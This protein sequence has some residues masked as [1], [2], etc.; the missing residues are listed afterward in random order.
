MNY[1]KFTKEVKRGLEKLVQ[2]KLDEGIV[3]IRNVT[4]NNNV[5]MRAVSIMRKCDKATP[6][7][8]LREYY[9]EHKHGKDI[10]DIC[11]EIFDVYL[12]GLDTLK[13]NISIKDLSDFD[14]IKE[15]IYYR[16]V[17]YEMNKT[18]LK[19]VPHIKFLDLAIIFYIMVACHEEGQA[20]ALIYNSH[21]EQW[22]K[23]F[24]EIRDIAFQN[25]WEK[26]PPVIK[27]ME[28]IVSE[29]L[30]EDMLAD[31]DMNQSEDG[32]IVSE[33]TKYGEYTYHEVR[34]MIRE[35]VEKLKLNEN[36]DMYVMTNTL[37]TNGAVCITYPGAIR[38]F[39][40]KKGEDIYII[41]SSVHEVILI[42]GVSWNKGDID[43]M[44]H[45]VNKTQL[46]PVDVLSNHVYIYRKDINEI[47]Y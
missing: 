1:E 17:N 26:Y 11:N 19:S 45:E 35:E 29:M 7:I 28:D 42:P 16:L 4:K 21:I 34:D 3:V 22:N 9:N 20:T 10:A 12:L 14:K 40:E 46:E 43:R 33:E 36:M 25:T 31:V 37:K 32:E 38:E 13:T 27:R 23:S 5:R 24:H 8:Y 30:I 6:T 41:P 44:I 2:E 39:A 47:E 18:M 15:Q